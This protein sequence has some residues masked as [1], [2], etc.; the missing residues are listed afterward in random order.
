MS[1]LKLMWPVVGFLALLAN[2]NGQN[3][4]MKIRSPR[5]LITGYGESG[6]SDHE[7]E[8]LRVFIVNYSDDTLRYWGANCRPSKFFTVS[9]NR[10]MHLVDRPCRDSAI[11]VIKIPPHRS[12]LIP[13]RLLV[14]KQPIGNIRISVRMNL[15]ACSSFTRFEED[16]KDRTPM[17]LKDN[18][19]L[20]YDKNGNSFYTWADGDKFEQKEKL[21]LPTTK[22][23]LLTSEERKLYTITAA[24]TQMSN[25][26]ETIYRGKNETVYTIPVMIH[27]NSD[28]I[29][30]YYSMT[31]SWIDF[32]RIDSKY[33]KIPGASCVGNLPTIITVP[34]HSVHTDTISFFYTK[35]F[36]KKPVYFKVGLNIN[37]NVH[38][39]LF[40]DE[41]QLTQYNIVWSNQIQFT[42]K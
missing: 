37:K 17:I 20:R 33:F 36:K 38:Y 34:A 1:K 2:A 6:N 8:V 26:K 35:K 7:Y 39:D 24:E 42:P 28:Q 18:I 10:Y 31:C 23:Y 5:L 15:Y 19:T 40:G 16:I 25:G 41:D 21:N 29:L 11:E 4:S 9:F 27:N 32:Y 30:E 22:F 13:L 14:S 12:Q 3:T